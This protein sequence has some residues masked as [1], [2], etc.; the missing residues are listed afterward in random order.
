[1]YYNMQCPGCEPIPS[2]IPQG[3]HN[4]STLSSYFQISV[5]ILSAFTYTVHMYVCTVH[6]MYHNNTTGLRVVDSLVS[7]HRNCI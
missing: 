4:S 6:V 5:T 1:M 7:V 3:M 2:P